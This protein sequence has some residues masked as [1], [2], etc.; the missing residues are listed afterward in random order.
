MH[1]KL[2]YCLLITVYLL[3]GCVPS[4]TATP[5]R[6]TPFPTLPLTQNTPTLAPNETAPV[7]P[8]TA[9]TDAPN[10]SPAPATRIPTAP[11][12]PTDTARLADTMPPLVQITVQDPEL[13]VS[14]DQN[15]SLNVIAA[16]NDLVTRLDVYDNNVLFAQVTAPEPAAVLSNQFQWSRHA[17]GKHTLRAVAF[18]AGGNASIPAQIVLNVINN[19]RAPTVLI[20]SP[21][22]SKDAEIG[23]P[24]TIQGVATDDVAVTR[25]DLIVDNQLVTFV[26]PD[27]PITPF[28]VAIPWTPTTTGAH[29]IVLRAY[30]NRGQSDD[31]LRYTVRVFDNQP[32]VVTANAERTN[33]PSGDVLL[34]EALALSSNGVARVELYVDEQLAATA[35]SQAVS[36]QTALYTTLASNELTD[37]THTLFVRAVDLVGHTADTE[38]VIFTV[39]PNAPRIERTT[40]TAQTK[41]TAL[42]PTATPT[43]PLILP[44]PPTVKVELVGD[45]LRVVLPAPAEIKIQAHGA[46]ELDR[47]E[48]WA[49]YPGESVAQLLMEES[50]KGA[51]DETLTFK[52]NAPRA[53]VVEVDA[54][55]TDNLGQVGRSTILR[56]TLEAPPARAVEPPG[57]DFSG[58][59]F[60]ASPAVRFDATFTQFGRALRG[61]L[62]EK[63]ASGA[64]LTGKIVSGAAGEKNVLFAVDFSGDAQTPQHTLVFDCSFQERPPQLT[65]N[66]TTENGER[67]SALFKPLG[68]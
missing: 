29:N 61:I 15:V 64:P 31:S 7:I 11:A 16:D 47:I 5:P 1:S 8:T 17:P 2:F 39:A 44:P 4:P 45:P 19:N 12:F 57:F 20:T 26:T 18:D 43:A 63:R 56:V 14:T 65:C 36:Q 27:K 42:P 66:Y 33:I 54:R 13:P 48:L 55:V 22:G 59:W 58:A 34:V 10:V 3:A 62:T 51:T 49:R 60:A 25:M 9:A 38:R 67:G 46:A 23:A 6:Q 21:S 41:A 30:D 53:G 24:L 32:P 50:G 37:G 52:W 35:N 68:Q 28:A 40:P